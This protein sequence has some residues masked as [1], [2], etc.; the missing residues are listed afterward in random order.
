MN[1]KVQVFQ[2]Q[3]RELLFNRTKILLCWNRNEMKKNKPSNYMGPFPLSRE[4]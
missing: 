3:L 1:Y 2:V 4:F